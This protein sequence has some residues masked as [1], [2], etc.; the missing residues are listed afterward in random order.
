MI[1]LVHTIY[2]VYIFAS[3]ALIVSNKNVILS[4]VTYVQQVLDKIKELQYGSLA[5]V[6]GRYYAMDR[7]KRFERNKIAFEG[8]V[9]GIGEVA[10]PETVI[11]V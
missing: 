2:Y 1:K 5:L 11:E 4:T 8:M 6:V 7:D 9:Q 10:T 3:F